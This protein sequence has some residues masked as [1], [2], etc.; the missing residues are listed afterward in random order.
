MKELWD[1]ELIYYYLLSI[2]IIVLLKSYK[3]E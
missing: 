3:Y 1:G 2:V